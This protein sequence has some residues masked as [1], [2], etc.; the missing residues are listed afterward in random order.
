MD[1]NGGELRAAVLRV[2]RMRGQLRLKIL[3]RNRAPS[4]WSMAVVLYSSAVDGRIDCIDF[5]NR[6]EDINGV[7]CSGFHRHQW[8][9]TQGSCERQKLVL[10]EFNPPDVAAFI[11]SGFALIEDRA[12]GGSGI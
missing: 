6:F 4:C 7:V 2:P 1:S 12:E 3:C 11:E 8:D 10:P 5:E 9:P